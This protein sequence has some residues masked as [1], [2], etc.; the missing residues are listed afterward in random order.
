MFGSAVACEMVM[1]RKVEKR[2]EEGSH[3]KKGDD[4]TDDHSV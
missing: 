3:A 2:R 1:G 4:G